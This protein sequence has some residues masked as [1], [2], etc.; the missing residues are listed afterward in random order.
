MIKNPTK[1]QMEKSLCNYCHWKD[2]NG[3]YCHAVEPPM[4]VDVAI[5]NAG[6][7]P[8]IPYTYWNRIPQDQKD[9]FNEEV[10]RC[11]EM[12]APDREGT[13]DKMLWLCEEHIDRRSRGPFNR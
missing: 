4:K 3:F 13:D 6:D 5:N 11:S 8:Y 7:C 1:E 9:K 2:S 12:I 10:K